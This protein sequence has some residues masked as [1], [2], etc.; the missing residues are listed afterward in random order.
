MRYRRVVFEECLS[1]DNAQA[2]QFYVI[3]DRDSSSVSDSASV[4]VSMLKRRSD[5]APSA[6]CYFSKRAR[7]KL[8]TTES[9][10]IIRG[11]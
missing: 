3:I 4:R 2:K 5:Y 7:S 9:V 1:H 8:Q 6:L 11:T 10:G